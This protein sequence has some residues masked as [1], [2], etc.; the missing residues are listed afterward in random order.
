M[1]QFVDRELEKLD[2]GSRFLVWSMRAWVTSMGQRTCPAQALAPAF[3]RWRMI[4]GLQAFHRTMLLFNRDAL[5]TFGFAPLACSRVS[6][7]E[8]VILSLII[9]L[10]DQGAGMA[11]G[12]LELMVQE[13]AVGDLLD[14]LTKVGAALAMAGIFPS[15]AHPA[16]QRGG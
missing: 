10:R 5:E 7:H 15:E 4:G 11:R 2:C 6:E 12:T 3:A 16:P 14:S 9:A 13:E 8:A 1:Y